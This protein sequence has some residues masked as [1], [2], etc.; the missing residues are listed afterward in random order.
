MGRP[1]AFQESNS[2]F[3]PAEMSLICKRIKILWKQEKAENN[4][5]DCILALLWETEIQ[6]SIVTSTENLVENWTLQSLL[7]IAVL[8]QEFLLTVLGGVGFFPE[9]SSE[10]P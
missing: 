6:T 9:I 3:N 5:I 10:V 4:S 2:S 7:C 8:H 1:L